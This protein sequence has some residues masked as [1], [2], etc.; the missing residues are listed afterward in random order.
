MAA[1]CLALCRQSAG[2]QRQYGSGGEQRFFPSKAPIH[3]PGGV[4]F[5]RKSLPIR[6]SFGLCRAC[7]RLYPRT[8]ALISTGNRIAGDDATDEFIRKRMVEGVCSTN[9]YEVAQA[10]DEAIVEERRVLIE[11]KHEQKRD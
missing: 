8:D 10:T 1:P 7:G 2:V 4:R 3:T 11:R 6:L 5:Q 9:D